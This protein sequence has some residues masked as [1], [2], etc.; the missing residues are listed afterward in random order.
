[1]N[2]NLTLGARVYCWSSKFSLVGDAEFSDENRMCLIDGILKKNTVE[3]GFD[4][5]M[6]ISF[7]SDVPDPEISILLDELECELHK[8][9]LIKTLEDLYRLI[10]DTSMNNLYLNHLKLAKDW[11]KAITSR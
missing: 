11:R 6:L 7:F 1:L 3:K 5:P 10:P 4:D 8:I 2:Y 9:E